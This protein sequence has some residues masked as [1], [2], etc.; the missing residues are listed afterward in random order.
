MT[1]APATTTAEVRWIVRGT[2]PPAVEAW[3]DALGAPADPERRTDRYLAPTDAALGLKWRDGASGT[4]GGPAVEPKR[5]DAVGDALR[6]GRAEA[7]VETWAKWSLPTAAD[8]PDDW[9]AVEKERRQRGIGTPDAGCALELTVLKVGGEAWWTVALEATGAD[10]AARTHSLAD[11]A[12]QWL[13][14][15][16]APTLAAADAMSYPAW[17]LSCAA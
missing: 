15:D 16:D 1:S 11:G 6:A 5:R 12:A 7:S 17:L 9:I 10:D 13:D 14:R 2:I 4:S 8:A 3:F